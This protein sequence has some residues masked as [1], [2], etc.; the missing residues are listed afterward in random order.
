MCPDAVRWLYCV[1]V[2]D[3]LID[4][5]QRA[6]QAAPDDVVL[7][8]DNGEFHV[9]GSPTITKSWAEVASAADGVV[10]DLDTPEDLQTVET[11]LDDTRG[12]AAHTRG[13]LRQ[14]ARRPTPRRCEP[15]VS[16]A[17]PS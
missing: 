11:T 17:A 6:V 2:G 9:A 10:C 15:R 5:L 8:R 14:L 4:S 3:E 7:S 1:A 16:S 13:M 12:G